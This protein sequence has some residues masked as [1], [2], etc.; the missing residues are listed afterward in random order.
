MTHSFTTTIHFVGSRME[1]GSD[2]L[3][4]AEEQTIVFWWGTSDA[5]EIEII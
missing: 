5:F 3:F 2:D 4:G 1:D